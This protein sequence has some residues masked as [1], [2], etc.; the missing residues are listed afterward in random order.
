MTDYTLRNK[1][2]GT[3]LLAFSN[4]TLKTA[5][6]QVQGR[7]HWQGIL[8]NKRPLLLTT[9]HGSSIVL[10]GY[11]LREFEPDKALVIIPDDEVG[12]DLGYWIARLG[13]HPYHLN[14]KGDATMA[15]ARRLADLIKLV[16]QGFGA[17]IAPD[18][19]DGPAYV[20]KPGVA[21]LAEKTQAVV[22]PVSAFTRTAYRVKRW[23]QKMFPRPYSRISLVIGQPLPAPT[24]AT[25]SQWLVDLATVLHKVTAQAAAY[26]YDTAYFEKING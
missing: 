3:G 26:Y 6:Y 12:G 20:P 10:A 8:E 23:D 24:K 17:F 14:L 1:V 16:K 2:M 19:P 5:R 11:F 21:Y 15:S 7:E 13:G 22:L 18:G 9:W 4:A 25:R